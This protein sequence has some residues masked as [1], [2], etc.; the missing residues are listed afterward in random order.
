[1]KVALKT[2]IKININFSWYFCWKLHFYQ[3]LTCLKSGKSFKN[4]YFTRAINIARL[5]GDD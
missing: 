5:K 2:E 4:I 1:M 3:G